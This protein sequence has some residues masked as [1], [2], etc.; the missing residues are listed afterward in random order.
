MIFLSILTLALALITLV[1]AVC[2][3][4]TSDSDVDQGARVFAAVTILLG[5]LVSVA[6][7]VEKLGGA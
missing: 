6:T 7:L 5:S 4:V 2:S 3:E 1:L